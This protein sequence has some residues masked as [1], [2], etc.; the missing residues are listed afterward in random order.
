MPTKP[1]HTTSRTTTTSAGKTS[2]KQA[3]ARKTTVEQAAAQKVTRNAAANKSSA[4]KPATKKTAKKTA[5][6]AAANT[7]AKKAAANTTAKKTT[8]KKTA[9]KKTA[10]KKTSK[11]TSANKTAKNAPANKAAAK[12]TAKNAAANK[13]PANKAAAK[14]A[15]KHAAANKPPANKATKK[16]ATRTTAT[17]AKTPPRRRAARG[18]AVPAA[19]PPLPA[20][21]R[22]RLHATL[23]AADPT[24]ILAD[25]QAARAGGDG[26]RARYADNTWDMGT[27]WTDVLWAACRE[28]SLRFEQLAETLPRRTGDFAGV[29][30][31]SAFFVDVERPDVLYFAPNP[32]MPAA[33]FVEIPADEASVR[34]V[35]AEYAGDRER[36][37]KQRAW[38]GFGSQLQIP[39]VYSG[40]L[41]EVDDH[42][43]DRFFCFSPVATTL[44]RRTY[45]SGSRFAYEIHAD[46]LFVW[47]L[48]WPPCTTSARTLESFKK[49]AP[50]DLP[51]DMPLDLVSAIHGFEYETYDALAARIPDEPDQTAGILTVL[52]AIGFRELAVA[53]D[54]RRHL[55]GDIRV[56]AALANVAFR[57]GWERLIWDLTRIID[58]PPMKSQ[59]AEALAGLDLSALPPDGG[60]RLVLPPGAAQASLRE[61]AA[62][63]GWRAQATPEDDPTL[64][65]EYHLEGHTDA[66]PR[67]I[68]W[69]DVLSLELSTLVLDN[70][71]DALPILE[72]AFPTTTTTAPTDRWRAAASHAAL[73]EHDAL[74]K[75]IE[76]ALAADAWPD[77][78]AAAR[79]VGTVRLRAAEA[80]VRAALAS[81]PHAPTRQ[82]LTAA[83]EALTH[84]H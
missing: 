40:E 59:I 6:K 30:V 83:L 28:R 1:S 9:A 68:R 37:R 26:Q 13:T 60:R 81:E 67:R 53:A 3:A 82:A 14:K 45:F 32:D 10:A 17:A 64:R 54:L 48:A 62:A 50:Y 8:A 61:L 39:N 73:G 16:V 35:L 34:T 44:S 23:R 22:A 57:Y 12:K 43:L 84:V 66:T 33:L 25:E 71:D 15:A 24:L 70:A 63:H 56:H 49:L 78:L 65:L 58:D 69:R 80:L 79:L 55:P 21:V 27:L 75:I 36:T 29:T 20:D 31:A 46:D 74:L 41:V 47:D 2:A 51:A 42:E 11:K 72:S 76:P 18:T 5:K 19:P 4:N 77:R 52:A 7:T 38:M